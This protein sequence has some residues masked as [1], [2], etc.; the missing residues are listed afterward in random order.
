MGLTWLSLKDVKYT[1]AVAEV[2]SP[3]AW[4]QAAGQPR[5]RSAQAQTRSVAQGPAAAAR[6]APWQRARAGQRAPRT[7]ARMAAPEVPP[8]L[9]PALTWPGAATRAWEVVAQPAMRQAFRMPR[10]MHA[11]ASIWN[12]PMQSSSN[13]CRI[14]SVPN[15]GPSCSCDFSRGVDFSV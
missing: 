5:E 10:Q 12:C 4:L 1:Y 7:A 8:G 6:R 9:A 2:S 3:A 13:R 14:L 11:F 15:V